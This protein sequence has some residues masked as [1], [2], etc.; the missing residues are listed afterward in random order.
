M[1]KPLLAFI[2]KLIN[3]QFSGILELSFYKGKL[4]KKVNLKITETIAE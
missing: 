4:S 2:N 3:S 1:I